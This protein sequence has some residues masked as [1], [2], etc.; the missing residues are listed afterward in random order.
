MRVSDTRKGVREL[1]EATLALTMDGVTD[2]T[3]WRLTEDGYADITGE[4][5]M[6]AL[7]SELRQF[8]RNN[9]GG[10]L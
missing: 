8:I 6:S 7:K 4:F 2:F 3:F 10:I 5:L 1:R 9:I